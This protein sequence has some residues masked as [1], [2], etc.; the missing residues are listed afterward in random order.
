MISSESVNYMENGTEV[1]NLSRDFLRTY[2]LP[3]YLLNIA[4][5][6]NFSYKL[7]NKKHLILKI[8]FYCNQV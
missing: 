2:D 5:L 6:L 1:F 7:S 4:Q 8:T 3:D